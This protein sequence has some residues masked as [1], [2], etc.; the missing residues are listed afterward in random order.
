MTML[1]GRSTV[2]ASP[3]QRSETTESWRCAL[4]LHKP[5]CD[6]ALLFDT[7]REIHVILRR[8]C[9]RLQLN[10]TGKERLL[11]QSD[12]VPRGARVTHWPFSPPCGEVTDYQLLRD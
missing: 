10:Y 3:A 7:N 12:W 6:A 5:V 1:S 9:E 11:Y 8:C 2:V 4:D